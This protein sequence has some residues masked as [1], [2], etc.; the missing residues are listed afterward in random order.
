MNRW[1]AAL[2]GILVIVGPGALYSF[3]LFS[4]PLIASF[5]WSTAA[6]TT[7]FGLANFF[8]GVGAFIG[9]R[10]QDR[11]GPRLVGITGCALWGIGNMLTRVAATLL[12]AAALEVW[13][14]AAAPVRTRTA[15]KARTMFFISGPLIL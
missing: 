1:A 4:A 13:V 14:V 10:W 2:I 8:L 15:T 11:V 7:A 12:F 6:T 9:G 3:S 5:H